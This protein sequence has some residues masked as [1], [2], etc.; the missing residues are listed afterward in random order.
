[1]IVFSHFFL[2]H[3]GEHTGSKYD[4]TPFSL[5]DITF[6]CGCSVFAETAMESDHQ[7]TTLLTLTFTTQKNGLRG[8]KRGHKASGDPLL[9]TKSAL[10]QSV[11]HLRVNN[12]TPSTPLAR[13]MT[14]TIQWKNIAPTMISKTIHT[15]V[16]F[17]GPNMG[18]EAKDV[19]THPLCAAGAMDLLCSGFHR[20]IIKM[21][22]LW[23]N[24]DMIR[25]LHVQ[26]EPVMR[27]F[28]KLLI[29]NGNYSFLPRQETPRF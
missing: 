27:N 12:K 11:L 3:P 6:S 19:S 18:F 16:M 17:C 14:Q 20:D 24:N 15:A 9:C 22:G 29:P 1:M 8:K 2:L 23:I 10:I 26:M 21:I 13:F 28:S 25:Y 5:K 7:A 4:S